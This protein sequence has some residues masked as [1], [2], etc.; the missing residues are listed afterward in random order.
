MG[1]YKTLL[2]QD[3]II[4]PFEVNKLFTFYGNNQL[5]GSEVGIDR[6]LGK[7]I[8]SSFR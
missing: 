4:T 6:F 2:A 7:N 5:I 8:T 3:I 1:A